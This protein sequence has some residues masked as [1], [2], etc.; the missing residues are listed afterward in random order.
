[1][2]SGYGENILMPTILDGHSKMPN[3]I[4]VGIKIL[5][6]P[7][8]NRVLHIRF[9]VPIVISNHISLVFVQ[10]SLLKKRQGRRQGL[11]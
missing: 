10:R 2:G 6:Y 8:S 5:S 7:C 1:M 11:R 3:K 4:P 9:R